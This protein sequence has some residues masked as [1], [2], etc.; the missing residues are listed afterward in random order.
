MSSMFVGFLAA[1]GIAY[2]SHFLLTERPDLVEKYVP[3]L[4]VYGPASD[5][6]T[7][8]NVRL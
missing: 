6:H 7:S 4:E 3:F 1:A 2:G 8:P 5:Q